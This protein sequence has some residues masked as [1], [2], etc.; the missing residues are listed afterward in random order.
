MEPDSFELLESARECGG[1][2]GG[3]DFLSKKF[4]EEKNY[5]SL[6]EARLMQ[7][8]L[9]L[10][11]D[12]LQ[13]GSLD[14]VPADVRPAYERAFVDAAREVGGLF[15]ADG[16][17][18]R[19]WPYY[20]AIGET[21]PIAAAIERVVPGEN[22]DAVIA[23]AFQERVNPRKGFELILSQY[24]IC[25]AITCFDQYPAPAGR[26]ESLHLLLRTLY[27]DLTASLRY[28][29]E[30]NEGHAPESER[31]SELIAGRDWLFE[32]NS[33]Y[34]DSSHVISVLRFSLDLDD[35]A[36]LRLALE[37]AEYGRKLA[38][39]FAFRGDPP[40]ED[41]YTD[42]AIYL[43]ALLGE[44]VDEAVAHFRRKAQESDPEQVGTAPA[45][46]LVTL[47][48]RLER[49]REAIAASLE[50][51]EGVPATQLGCPTLFQL[52]QMAGEWDQL[53][54]LARERGDL[55]SF[56]AGL[57]GRRCATLAS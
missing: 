46:V 54:Q 16:D 51:L 53:R 13:I 38:P 41:V 36:M 48:V 34:I 20:R 35:P 49:L 12:P 2:A 1:A 21:A 43:R 6:F 42:H 5:P 25:R 15:L 8:R 14:D 45:Q 44:D 30:R 33:Y 17:L 55:L 28:A 57:L 31:V 18:V 56:A 50:F 40:F 4:R 22:M 37:M 26:E 7:K 11:L 27:Q 39:M 23:I 47:L 29:V 3:F 52:C 9:E 32:N 10:G 24:G 19:A